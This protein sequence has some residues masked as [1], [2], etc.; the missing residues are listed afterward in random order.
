MTVTPLRR[1]L[2]ICRVTSQKNFGYR[3]AGYIGYGVE[4][5]DSRFA[6]VF[7]KLD[8]CATI[9]IEAFRHFRLCE[10]GIRSRLPKRE[11]HCITSALT[12]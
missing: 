9:N 5:L 6:R 2:Y 11:L 10:A 7:L 8:V 4:L 1:V 12:V 3:Y